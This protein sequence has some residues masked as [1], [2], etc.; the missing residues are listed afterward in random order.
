MT[1][2]DNDNHDR[3]IVHV[4]PSVIQELLPDDVAVSP[5]VEQYILQELQKELTEVLQICNCLELPKINIA[6]LRQ[7]LATRGFKLCY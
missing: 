5:D 1:G 6:E 2:N 3:C 4:E 7:I